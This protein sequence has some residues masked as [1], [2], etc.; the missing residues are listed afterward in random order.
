M[1]AVKHFLTVCRRGRFSKKQRDAVLVFQ[2]VQGLLWILGTAFQRVWCRFQSRLPRF[3]GDGVSVLGVP[4]VKIGP[5]LSGHGMI[6]G[7]SRER[8]Y[9]ECCPF[10]VE[11]EMYRSTHSRL[12]PQIQMGPSR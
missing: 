8:Q 9:A 4:E 6:T 7:P 3:D 12:A 1:S 11:S 5:L 10:S 2:S